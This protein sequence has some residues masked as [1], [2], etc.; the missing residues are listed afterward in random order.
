MYRERAGKSSV[1]PVEPH[2]SKLRTR[3]GIE[4]LTVKLNASPAN[5]KS[6]APALLDHGFYRGKST[7]A[8]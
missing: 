6:L 3:E 4:S 2:E 8:L 7:S 5:F 1:L